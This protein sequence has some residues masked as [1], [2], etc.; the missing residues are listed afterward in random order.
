MK[1]PATMMHQRRAIMWQR[2][3]RVH[4]QVL[5]RSNDCAWGW[6]LFVGTVLLVLVWAYWIVTGG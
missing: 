2:G 1:R 4:A 6:L 5:N 3:T